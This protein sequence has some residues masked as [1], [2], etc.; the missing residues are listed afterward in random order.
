M[1]FV[2]K[3]RPARSPRWWPFNLVAANRRCSWYIRLADMCFPTFISRSVSAP[4]NPAMGCRPEAWKTGKIPSRGLRT[5]PYY[6]QAMQTVQ[7]TGP[8]R[9]G[10]WSM[11]GVVAFEM[12]QQLHAQGQPVAL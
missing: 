5:W 10:G 2:D 9:L 6:I 4:I 1:S 8:Y 12:A 3:P 11:G 7:P